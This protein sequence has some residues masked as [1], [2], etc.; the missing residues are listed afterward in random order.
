MIISIYI[1]LSHGS[2][3]CY[4]HMQYVPEHTVCPIL[5]V[6]WIKECWLYNM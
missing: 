2:Y 4:I 3:A 1:K 6:T 5:Y